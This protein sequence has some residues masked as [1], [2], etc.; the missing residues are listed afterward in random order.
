MAL[1]FYKPAKE[2]GSEALCLEKGDDQGI[3]SG[4]SAL[5]LFFLLRVRATETFFI[6]SL[7]IP[8]YSGSPEHTVYPKNNALLPLNR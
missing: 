3:N 2:H 1:R 4:E 8:T 6:K 5:D 7:V